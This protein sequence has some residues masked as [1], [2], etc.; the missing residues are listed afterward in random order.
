MS[1]PWTTTSKI[2]EI[3]SDFYISDG[4]QDTLIFNIGTTKLEER[5]KNPELDKEEVISM[6]KGSL[7][8]VLNHTRSFLFDKYPNLE[9]TSDF[10]ESLTI[11]LNLGTNMGYSMQVWD[12]ILFSIITESKYPFKV[13]ITIQEKIA[14][15]QVYMNTS[16][17]YKKFLDP[18]I[19][20]S[21]NI[22]YEKV[23]KLILMNVMEA[24]HL[25]EEELDQLLGEYHNLQEL[26]SFL[27]Q[28]QKER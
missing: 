19:Q 3:I 18:G 7:E 23:I 11:N 6:L 4:R 26:F 9:D 12:W 15:R 5:L 27:S 14:E 24:Y 10:V 8:V 21:I 17:I 2:M 28:F 25:K 13:F 20:P 16:S 22:D 1:S